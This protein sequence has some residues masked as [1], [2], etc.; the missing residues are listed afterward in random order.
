MLAH[1]W[2]PWRKRYVWQQISTWQMGQ[3]PAGAE[4]VTVTNV[5]QLPG[6]VR[7]IGR[8]SGTGAVEY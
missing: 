3:P 4:V 1:G 7:A 8:V 2:V 6:R 5:A